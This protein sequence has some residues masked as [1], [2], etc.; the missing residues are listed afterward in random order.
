MAVPV[1]ITAKEVRDKTQSGQA[2]LVC[3]YDDVDKFK[4]FQ[5]EGAISWQAFNEK[6]PTLA[7]DDDNIFYCA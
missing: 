3:A 1:R 4:E 6:L 5:L 7:K 2:L